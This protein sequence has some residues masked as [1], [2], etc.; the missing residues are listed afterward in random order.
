MLKRINMPAS[1]KNCIYQTGQAMV[2][3]VV[4][5]VFGV[6]VLTIGPGGDVILDL[7]GVMND[8]HQ[9][10]SYA[11]SLSTLPDYDNLADYVLDGYGEDIDTV[12]NKLKELY[13]NVPSNPSFEFPDE[14]PSSASDILE[15]VSIF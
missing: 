7:L 8:N 1:N 3:Y 4:V 6:M 2:E 10:Y 13:T 11:T 12:E 5:L 14:M 15:G 9:G